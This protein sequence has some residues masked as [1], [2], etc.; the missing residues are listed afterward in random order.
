MHAFRG[1]F[2]LRL[3]DAFKNV[4][5]DEFDL[6][7]YE[8]ES[9]HVVAKDAHNVLQA[10]HVGASVCPTEERTVDKVAFMPSTRWTGADTAS[11][12]MSSMAPLIAASSGV[13]VEVTA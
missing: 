5:R 13:P 10:A 9:L 12:V 3:A 11:P 2:F 4:R 7:L 1:G 8:F 6:L